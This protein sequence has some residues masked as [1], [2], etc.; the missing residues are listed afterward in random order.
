MQSDQIDLLAAALVKAQAAMKPAS[1]NKINPHFKSKYAD[2]ASII[3]SLRKPLTDNGLAFTQTLGRDILP[4]FSLVTT[5]LHTSGQWL[6]SEYPL[7]VNATPQQMGSALTYARRYSLSAITGTAA[8]EDDDGDKA[9]VQAKKKPEPE[10]TYSDGK[11]VAPHEIE[12]PDKPRA[13]D[14]IEFGELLITAVSGAENDTEARA[15][16]AANRSRLEVMS[17]KDF[18][19]PKIA[20]RLEQ[21]LLT[22]GPK[23]AP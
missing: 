18:P 17:E 2:L 5:L 13:S 1:M 4:E 6:R 15:W 21:A 12:M 20:Q 10:P 23:N 3:E 19:Y 9:E 22:M 11:K 7:P 8:D 16:K 14:W